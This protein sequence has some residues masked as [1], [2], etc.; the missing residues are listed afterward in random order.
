MHA[1]SFY[2]SILN[3]KIGSCTKINNMDE[4]VLAI[5]ENNKKLISLDLWK[6]SNLT[7]VGVSAL[8]QCSLLEEVDLGWWLVF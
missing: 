1:Y 7:Q 3:I 6:T 2:L 5:S 4:V 8:S